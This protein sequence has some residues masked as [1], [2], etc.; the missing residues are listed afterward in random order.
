MIRLRITTLLSI[1]FLN[2]F[3]MALLIRHLISEKN[4]DLST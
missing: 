3:L 1:L 4:A 2:V